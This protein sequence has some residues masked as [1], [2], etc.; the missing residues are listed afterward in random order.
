MHRAIR[1]QYQITLHARLANPADQMQGHTT[2]TLLLP[3]LSAYLTLLH[4]TFGVELSELKPSC[5]VD[6]KD[7]H[8]FPRQLIG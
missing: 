2:P 3:L 4:P 8:Q 5:F 7:Q 1:N 6:P